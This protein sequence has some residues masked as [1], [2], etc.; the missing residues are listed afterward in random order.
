VS[1]RPLY[2]FGMTLLLLAGSRASAAQATSTITVAPAAVGPLTISTAVAGQQPAGVAAG[3]G[4]YALSLKNNGGLY[5]ITARLS[6][7]LP[8]GT[9]LSVNLASPANGG[10][11]A[12]AVP[13]TTSAQ[14]VVVNLPTSKSSSSGNAISYSFSATSAAGVLAMQTIS[15]ILELA[16]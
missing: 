12:G 5:T 10:Q 9:T 11:S 14:P 16:P 15:V 4:T 13:L 6:A 2:L 3:G 1:S 7:P 8:A